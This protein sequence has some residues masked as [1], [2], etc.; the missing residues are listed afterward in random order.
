MNNKEIKELIELS[1]NQDI[2]K[3]KITDGDFKI[4][5]DRSSDHAPV[6]PVTYTHHTS[7]SNPSH[8]HQESKKEEIKKEQ[9]S[10]ESMETLDSPMVGSFYASPKP[11]APSFVE[12]GS[13]VK[14]GDTVGIIEAMKIMNELEAEFSFRV[15]KVLL[16]DGSPVEYGTPI[17]EIERI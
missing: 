8:S 17:F 6:A 12:I 13:K 3:I 4:E 2:K 7:S 14:K 9:V 10:T 5:I 1:V 16:E 15:V 11:G